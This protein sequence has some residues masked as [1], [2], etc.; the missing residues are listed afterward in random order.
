MSLGRKLEAI[1]AERDSLRRSLSVGK[2]NGVLV[3]GSAS[4]KLVAAEQVVRLSELESSSIQLRQRIVELDQELAQANAAV[5]HEQGVASEATER[6]RVADIKVARLEKEADS[7]ARDVATLQEK[8]GSGLSNNK[9][10]MRVLHL[11]MNPETD[12]HKTARDSKVQELRAENKRHSQGPPGEGGASGGGPTSRAE[13]PGEGGAEGAGGRSGSAMVA[14]REAEIAV[15]KHRVS[16]SEKVMVRLKEVTKE[17][18]M[19]FREACYCLFGYRVDMT[20]EATVARDAATAPTT[21]SLKPQHADDPSAMLVFKYTKARGME[22][23]PTAFSNRLAREVETFVLKFNSIPAL[24]A[25][26]TM[27]NFQKQTMC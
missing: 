5:T 24:T 12:Y 17:R 8:L 19:A 9:S 4:G 21:F 14:V 15:L 23:V 20:S 26:L 3:P 16:E 13:R 22:L 18:I 1:T 27:E 6:A 2:D 7:L 10:S 11:K 25:N